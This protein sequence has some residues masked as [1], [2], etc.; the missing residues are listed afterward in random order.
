MV[1]VYFL[2]LGW[3]VVSFALIPHILI[4]KDSTFVNP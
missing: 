4:S 1:D 2:G 3:R